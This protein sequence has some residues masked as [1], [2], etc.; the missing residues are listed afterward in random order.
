MEN[1]VACSLGETT[2]QELRTNNLSF[3]HRFAESAAEHL[4]ASHHFAVALLCVCVGSRIQIDCIVAKV[5]YMHHLLS[6]ARCT[7]PCVSTSSC[8]V[9]VPPLGT[10]LWFAKGP[11]STS[12]TCAF[13]LRYLYYFLN[14]DCS[15]SSVD[16]AQQKP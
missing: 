10:H 8:S 5:A 9:Y 3:P 13:P 16:A 12:R 14:D 2:G 4:R 6:F 11:P 1:I 15:L 7:M